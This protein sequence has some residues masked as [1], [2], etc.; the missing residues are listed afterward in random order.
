[1]SACVDFLLLLYLSYVKEKSSS[2]LPMIVQLDRWC[3]QTDK[4]K[5]HVERNTDNF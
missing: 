5:E 4:L 2:N 3:V 1:M